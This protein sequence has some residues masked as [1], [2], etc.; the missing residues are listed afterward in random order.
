MFEVAVSGTISTQQLVSIE[1]GK[2]VTK[3]FN[4]TRIYQEFGVSPNDYQLVLNASSNDL[5][6]LVPK[7][8]GSGLTNIPVVRMSDQESLIDT[9]RHLALFGAQIESTAT[10]NV[11]EEFAGAHTGSIKVKGTLETE[12]ITKV[13]LSL[14]AQGSG[15]GGD[16]SSLFK[17]KITTGKRFEQAP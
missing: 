17:L 7:S 11:F 6:L 14:Y 2:I 3:A 10:G 13:T 15:P 8:A 12:N 9:A 1:A 5:L 16:G 4:N